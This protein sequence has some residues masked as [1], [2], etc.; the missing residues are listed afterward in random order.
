MKDAIHHLRHTQKKMIQSARKERLQEL[1]TAANSNL[2]GNV[3]ESAS[4]KTK[5]PSYWD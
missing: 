2:N 4:K 5:K 3:N 1:L